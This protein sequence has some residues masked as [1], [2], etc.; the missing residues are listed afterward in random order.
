MSAFTRTLLLALL[1]VCSQAVA[2]PLTQGSGEDDPFVRFELPGGVRLAVLYVADAPRQST[3]TFLPLGLVSDGPGETQFNDTASI[4]VS[5]KGF[6][7]QDGDVVY[8]GKEAY[9]A[10]LQINIV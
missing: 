6:C 5:G 4:L 10:Q 1:C 7:L 8:L 3:F 2:A 9:Q